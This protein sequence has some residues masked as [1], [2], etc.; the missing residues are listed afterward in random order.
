[1]TVG[2]VTV[3]SDIASKVHTYIK[4]VWSQS[5]SLVPLCE[6]LR[7]ALS[8]ETSN[9]GKLHAVYAEPTPAA[10]GNYPLETGNA[11]YTLVF[12]VYSLLCF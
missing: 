12:G 10:Q 1:M 3:S 6:G 4:K 5:L 7:M 8:V 2:F 11:F 9:V